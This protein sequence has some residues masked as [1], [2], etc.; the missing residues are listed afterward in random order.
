M[1]NSAHSPTHASST[2]RRSFVVAI[3]NPISAFHEI[4]KTARPYLGVHLAKTQSHPIAYTLKILLQTTSQIPC[5]TTWI[6]N[7]DSMP[8]LALGASVPARMCSRPFS[9]WKP[10]P[11]GDILDGF[12]FRPEGLTEENL[13]DVLRKVSKQNAASLPLT[14]L[15]RYNPTISIPQFSEF[16]NP[17]STPWP[18][19]PLFSPSNPVK[20]AW[21]HW[22]L[23]S[24]SS[25]HWARHSAAPASKRCSSPASA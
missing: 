25:L 16:S 20:A 11:Q 24:C 8:W 9:R 4:S 10:L 13:R 15:I 6:M 5:S 7:N 22:P 12:S 1:L 17:P 3:S 14:D 19:S 18:A 23:A 2:L 21:L